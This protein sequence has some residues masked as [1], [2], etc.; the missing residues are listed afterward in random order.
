MKKIF[1]LVT[2]KISGSFHGPLSERM[3]PPLSTQVQVPPR[4]SGNSLMQQNK[5]II[6]STKRKPKKKNQRKIHSIRI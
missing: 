2:L 5:Q 4:N 6:S 1:L 3:Q